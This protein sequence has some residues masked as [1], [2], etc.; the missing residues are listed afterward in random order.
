MHHAIVLGVDTPIGLA[1]A[2]D[3]ADHRVAVHGITRNARSLGRWSRALASVRDRPKDPEALLALIRRLAVET[4]ARGI[5]TISEG[6]LR[7]LSGVRERLPELK[8][9]APRAEALARVIDKATTLEAARAVGV[10][11]PRSET[12][13]TLDEVAPLIPRLE[14]PVVLKWS[15]PHL[16]EEPL[17]R[18]GLEFRKFE[19][20]YDGDALRQILARYAPV[21]VFPLIQSF[22]PGYGLG[23]MVVMHRGQAILRFQHRRLQE[24]PPEGGV[25]TLCESVGLDQ[26]RELFERSVALLHRL[27][28]EGPAMVEYRHDP[29][30]GR[31]ALME[32]NGRFWGSLPLAYHAGA[33]FA[34]TTF[35]ACALGEIPPQPSYTVGLRCMFMVPS[36]RR[37]YTVLFRPE[38]IQNRA[39]HFDPAEEILGWARGALGPKTSYY[40]FSWRDPLPAAIDLAFAGRAA[41]QQGIGQAIPQAL[42]Q[43]VGRL[44][45]SIRRRARTS[46]Y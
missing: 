30:T 34:W 21:G 43:V 13:R 15:D 29:G 14:F 18:H 1:V 33:H 23:Q 41:L 40:V 19:Y 38:A 35:S 22:A 44:T 2:R 27:E 20:A 9:L 25:S 11:V 8:V 5:M 37:L 31:S 6:D 24:W 26:H 17:R 12:I 42:G 46:K 10:P 3:L 28:W 7:W 32:V 39:L 45:G 36:A 16:V 4:G